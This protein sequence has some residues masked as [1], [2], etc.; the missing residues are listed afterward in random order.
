[1]RS[2]LAVQSA[3]LG[4]ASHLPFTRQ[5]PPSLSHPKVALPRVLNKSRRATR[6]FTGTQQLDRQFVPTVAEPND[7]SFL[8]TVY[9]GLPYA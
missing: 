2:S 6:N 9:G 1:M 5:M 8:N 7:G 3:R 4:Y